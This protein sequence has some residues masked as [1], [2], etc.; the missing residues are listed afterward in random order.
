MVPLSA[1]FGACGVPSGQAP[2]KSQSNPAVVP[3]RPH[4][5]ISLADWGLESVAQV[6][7]VSTG[8][9]EM[10]GKAPRLAVYDVRP[11]PPQKPASESSL[12]RSEAPTFENGVYVLSHFD[13][14]NYNRLGGTFS[15]FERAPSAGTVDLRTRQG[16]LMF[17]YQRAQEGFVGFWIHL[18]DD[19]ARPRDRTYL[20]TGSATF[21]S[22]E[23]KG[24]RG[25]EDV[26]LR[27]ADRNWDTREDSLPIGP[28]ARFLP[29]KRI[30]RRWQRALVPLSALPERI[31]REELAA[32]LFSVE[33]P[34][35]GEITLRN[36]ALVESTDAAVPK[37][38]RRRTPRKSMPRALWV[39]NTRA[40]AASR[41]SQARLVSFCRDHQIGEVFLQL[42]PPPPG[43]HRK[44]RDLAPMLPLVQEL[45]RNG[46]RVDA[47]DGDPHFALP[48]HHA[49]VLDTIRAV[50]HSNRRAP[51]QGRFDGIR[52]DNEPY[53]L[54]GFA[55]PNKEAILRSYLE[56][57]KRAR[58]LTRRHKLRL[59]AD[60]P[61]WF[62]GR[63]RFEEAIAALDGRPLSE[64][65]IDRV[66]NVAI[67]AYRTNVYGPDGVIA[68]SLDEI[69]Y[70]ERRGKSIYV[71]LET[72]QL[73]DET[74]QEFAEGEQQSDLLLLSPAGGGTNASDLV[75]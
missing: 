74:L 29:K 14:G 15:V 62:D 68:H 54:P 9:L 41:E 23:I 33:S 40:L 70:A 39:W 5:T 2:K 67:M 4:A 24:R 19:R 63:T 57:L 31:E 36:L 51:A 47:L 48:K 44:A 30:R 13:A 18:Y 52:F 3:S 16:G 64:L 38:R 69:E 72:I 20:H 49:R 28:V 21:I 11:A 34:S 32:L 26:T 43:R 45:H 61:F 53:L 56:L 42:L 50:I 66:D 1:A 35:A 46:I 65:V 60:I 27:I 58:F 10:E 59:G 7:F 17:R 55:G 75:R 37:G 22:F 71:A 25:G 73:P 6:G 12:W 8:L